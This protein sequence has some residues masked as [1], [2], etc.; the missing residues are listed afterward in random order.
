MANKNLYHTLTTLLFLLTPEKAHK[1]TLKALRTTPSPL[2]TSAFQSKLPSSLSIHLW[3]RRFPNPVGLAAGFD[4][5]AESLGGLFALGFGFVEAGTV[6]IKPQA[7]NPEPR[8]FRCPEHKAI[9]NRMGFPNAGVAAFK[10]NL[11]KFLSRKPRPHGVLGINIGMNKD[12]TDPA[13]DYTSLIRTLAP[14]AD[15]LTV[16]ISSPNTPGLRNLQEKE[17]LT[18]LLMAL[19]AERKKSCGANPPPLLV[20]LAPDLNDTQIAD[21]SSVLLAL[22]IDG[23]IL[24]NTTLDRPD[25]LPS[26][27]ASEKGGLSGAPLTDKSTEVIRK[28]YRLT[29]GQIP[30]IGVGGISN[31][32]QAYAKIRAGASLVQI[33]SALVYEGPGLPNRINREL[34][35]LLKR[36]GF[37]SLE[38]AIGA[39]YPDITNSTKTEEPHAKSA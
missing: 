34:A 32:E 33:Y 3:N 22:D 8:I 17:P 39:D 13:K 19:L 12:Q 36:D 35:D 23:I 29:K 26:E 25:F 38:Q 11:E 28:F 37:K 16:N 4:K 20:K 1:L 21:I 10:A 18:D 5:N 31:G 30:I 9:I 7:G 14:M 27:F 15:Y 6:T 2:L 24:T